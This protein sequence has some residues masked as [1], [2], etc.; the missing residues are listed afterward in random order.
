MIPLSQLD[1]YPLLDDLYA[2]IPLALGNGPIF[3]DT[4]RAAP[5]VR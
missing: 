5:T 2:V 1:D 3:M 4:T